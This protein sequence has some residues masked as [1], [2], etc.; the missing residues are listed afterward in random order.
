MLQ[1][2]QNYRI[3]GGKYATDTEVHRHQQLRRTNRDQDGRD[4][5]YLIIDHR[6]TMNR[7][8]VARRSLLMVVAASDSH[9]HLDR[10]LLLL[11]NHLPLY[12]IIYSRS[13]TSN[14]QS[15]MWV[16]LPHLD[17]RQPLANPRLLD[18][19]QADQAR[20]RMELSISFLPK[21]ISLI[22]D[23]Q[24]HKLRLASL[25]PRDPWDQVAAIAVV[26]SLSIQVSITTTTITTT[27][28]FNLQIQASALASDPEITS[29]TDS[30]RTR[31]NLKTYQ[32]H[33]RQTLL[34]I[35]NNNHRPTR[36]PT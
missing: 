10:V 28:T 21:I 4:L 22:A 6:R 2:G 18:N 20:H 16:R 8:L 36:N 33:S 30:H 5:V 3:I 7:L 14:R 27:T 12:K 1:Q 31:A 15:Q 35:S 17:G 9:R 34:I 19:Y 32:L 29:L 23:L 26:A 24:I 25:P 13:R 11:V